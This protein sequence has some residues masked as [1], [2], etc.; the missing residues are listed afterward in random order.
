[1]EYYRDEKTVALK[2]QIDILEGVAKVLQVTLHQ[3]IILDR[4]LQRNDNT[5][6][7]LLTFHPMLLLLV[8]SLLDW[9][10]RLGGDAAERGQ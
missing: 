7:R 5:P 3:T 9:T 6:R 4:R 2:L 1:M 8:G 10:T